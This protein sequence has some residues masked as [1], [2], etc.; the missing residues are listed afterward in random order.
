MIQHNEK[1]LVQ[2][3]RN[4]FYKK[5]QN[6]GNV[7]YLVGMVLYLETKSLVFFEWEKI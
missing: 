2:V 7:I 1:P 6:Q 5:Y 3:K 4:K